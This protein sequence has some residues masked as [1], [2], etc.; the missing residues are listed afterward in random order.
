MRWFGHV[1]RRQAIA[2]VRRVESI[3]V[4]G[5]RRRGRPRRTW[6]EQL[7]LDMKALN[8]DADMTLDKSSWRCCIRVVEP[9]L[10][11]GSV[12]ESLRVGFS[13]LVLV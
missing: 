5:V 12:V 6:E 7:R 3:S 9:L 2:P 1:R 11:S 8:L 13:R 4:E 10:G